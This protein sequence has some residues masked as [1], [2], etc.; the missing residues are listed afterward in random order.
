ML[1]VALLTLFRI[2]FP[3][4]VSTQTALPPP[5]TPQAEEC[6]WLHRRARPYTNSSSFGPQISALLLT[7][8]RTSSRESLC[9]EHHWHQASSS[10]TSDAEPGT[11]FTS[12]VFS[13]STSV[14]STSDS[15]ATSM[16]ALIFGFP[17]LWISLMCSIRRA[18][19]FQVLGRSTVPTSTT[20]IVT[21]PFVVIVT[22]LEEVV[23]T[24]GGVKHPGARSSPACG[25]PGQVRGGAGENVGGGCIQTPSG[26]G[27]SCHTE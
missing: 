18:V 14:F 6:K 7:T 4:A 16:A 9:R 27:C 11:L 2:T 26:E 23:G 25:I 5:P 1:A 19:H 21:H 20:P 24:S 10:E 13:G 15:D 3:V 22:Q 8:E 12:V 17:Y